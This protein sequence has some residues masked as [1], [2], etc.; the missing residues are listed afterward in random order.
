MAYKRK[1]SGGQGGRYRKLIRTGL[2]LAGR[3]GGSY[4]KNRYFKKRSSENGV[5]AQYD[6]VTQYTKKYM[7]KRKKRAWKKFSKK[8]NAVLDKSLGTRT[9]VFNQG[10]TMT[11][12]PGLQ[13]FGAATLYGHCGRDDS[14]DVGFRDIFRICNRDSDIMTNGTDGSN[15]SKII[16]TSAVIDFTIRNAGQ[17][18][19]ELDMYEIEVRTDN[20]KEANFNSSQSEA[21]VHTNSIPGATAGLGITVR[22]VTLFDVPNLISQDK[23]KIFRKKKFFLPPG[24]TCTHQYRDPRNHYY[25]ANQINI[26]DQTEEGSYALRKMTKMFVFIGKN[27]VGTDTVNTNV[28]VGVTRK[29]SYIINQSSK[30]LDS[31]NPL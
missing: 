30:A 6:K 22:G 4:I 8:V 24:N 9:V 29:Y 18:P 12:I 5:T 17:S 25:N 16:F 2:S 14:I 21:F 26:F 19:I 20:T 15:P 10:M 23:L 28:D 27:I 1:Y 3:I 7:P 31:L 11:D 13:C